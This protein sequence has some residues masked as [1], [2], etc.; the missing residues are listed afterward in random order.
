M[1]GDIL[2]STRQSPQE[3]PILSHSVDSA[4]AGSS[5]QRSG[6]WIVSCPW[7]PLLAICG[8]TPAEQETW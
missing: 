3:R 7:E 5:W 4:K 1:S 2:H 6:H 8:V